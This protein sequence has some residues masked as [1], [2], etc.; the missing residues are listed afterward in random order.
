[1]SVERALDILIYLNREGTSVG[2]SQIAKDL[3]VYKSTVHRT[4]QTLESRHFV[5]QD[6]ETGKYG[7]GVIFISMAAKIKKYDLF[8]PFASRLRAEFRETINVSVM[9]ET[10]DDIYKSLIVYKEDSDAGILSVSPRLGS[11]IECYC[12][13]VGKCLLAFTAGVSEAKLSRYRFVKYTANTIIDKASLLAELKL[14]RE[15]G[16][17]LD[18]E[19]QEVGLFCVGVPILNKDGSAVAAMSL[20]GPVKRMQDH[21]CSLLIGRLKETAAEITP[22][23]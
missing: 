2:V 12:S 6:K 5:E 15:R 17:A 19:E 18:N 14:I 4:L 13:S 7:L 1:M 9:D 11:S 22:L 8:R 21:D 10:T 16:Y 3:G 20:S 23:L